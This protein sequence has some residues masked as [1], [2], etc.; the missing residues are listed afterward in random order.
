[1][2]AGI[3]RFRCGTNIFST[4]TLKWAC[5]WL[6]FQGLSLVE[7]AQD[8]ANT[9][10]VPPN[11]GELK[12]H[13]S[14]LKHLLVERFTITLVGI[15][16]SL[17]RLRGNVPAGKTRNAC[18]QSK[19]RASGRAMAYNA[20]NIVHMGSSVQLIGQEPEEMVFD[21]CCFLRVLIGVA[22]FR[23]SLPKCSM[24]SLYSRL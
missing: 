7:E 20:K 13:P 23:W 11:V 2:I 12:Y 6:G 17:A 18:V 1:V 19:N 16:T 4:T 24:Q 5:L 22:L 15:G 21:G 3:V 8:I 9:S 10:E 14:S